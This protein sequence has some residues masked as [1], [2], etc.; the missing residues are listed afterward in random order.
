MDSTTGRK[1]KITKLYNSIW[2]MRGKTDAINNIN[3]DLLMQYCR[4][5]VISNEISEDIQNN[6]GEIPETQLQDRLATYKTM[7]GI[8]TSL[9]RTLNLK[10]LN[11]DS[12]NVENPYL[13]LMKE[14]K[15]I[16]D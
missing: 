15:E 11:D 4:F 5:A 7:N 6:I 12:P 10:A 13:E 14:A 3:K 1:S 2:N 9:Y 16:A 8:A